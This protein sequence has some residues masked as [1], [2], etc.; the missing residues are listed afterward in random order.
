V[1]IILLLP[2]NHQSYTLY[3]SLNTQRNYFIHTNLLQQRPQQLKHDAKRN[4]VRFGKCGARV[5][6][7]Y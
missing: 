2:P 6:P 1:T 3:I 7:C 5:R 4:V